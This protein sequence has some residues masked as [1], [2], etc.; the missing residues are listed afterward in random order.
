MNKSTFSVSAELN[1]AWNLTGKHWLTLL[2]TIVLSGLL[3]EAVNLMANP[4]C[5]VY[6]KTIQMMALSGGKFSNPDAFMQGLMLGNSVS[7]FRIMLFVLLT[8]ALKIMIYGTVFRLG[9][10]ARDGAD[11]LDV[12][13]SI[14]GT[15]R[16]IVKLFLVCFLYG[17][18]VTVGIMLCI[19]PGIFLA[20]R[21]LFMPIIVVDHPE[22]SL[23]DV[24]R[25]SWNLTRGNFW[26]LLLAGI[27]DLLITLAGVICCC[28][29]LFFAYVIILLFYTSI[30]RT[31]DSQLPLTPADADR[32]S[33]A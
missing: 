26:R 20:A 14:T 13:A 9:L 33:E 24:F 4:Y 7:V 29:G 31:L 11:K 18:I 32:L 6:F 22:L 5:D 10:S 15:F 27:L 2:L 12:Q 1:R 3:L 28:V 25:R 17:L 19:I 8:A 21:L 30:Y 16:I 23:E